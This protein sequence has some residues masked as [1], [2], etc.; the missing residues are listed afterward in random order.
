MFEKY[1]QTC[2]SSLPYRFRVCSTPANADENVRAI[3][4]HWFYKPCI[5]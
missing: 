4:T 5:S 1:P 2:P 3:K